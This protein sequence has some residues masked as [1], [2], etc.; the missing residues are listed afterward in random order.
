MPINE[1]LLV[2][3]DEEIKKTRTMLERVPE[4]KK[5]FTPH[6][7]SMP[8]NKLAP[9]VAQLAG[10]PREDEEDGLR[11]LLCLVR[12]TDLPQ[13]DGINEIDVPRGQFSERFFGIVFGV[14]PQ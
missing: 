3:F 10:F 5:E 1:L 6:P 9:H 14:L 7:K 4:D 2:E 12:I 8:L 13:R 11:N